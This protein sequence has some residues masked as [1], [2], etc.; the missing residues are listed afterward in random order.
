MNTISLRKLRIPAYTLLV[1]TLGACAGNKER[2]SGDEIDPLEPAN[3]NMFS[4]NESLDENIFKPV[5]QGYVNITSAPVRASVTNFF[6]NAS[7][8]NTILNSFLQGE[9]GHGFADIGRFVVNSTLG[10][11]GLFDVATDMGLPEREKDTGQTLARWGAGEGAY[12]FIPGP[13]SNTIRDSSNMVTS[14]LLFPF[15]Y[16]SAVVLLPVT[17]VMA[18]NARANLLTASNIRDEA[19][20]DSYSFTREVYLQQ[21][22]NLIYGK[23][24]P[25]SDSF[26]GF[27]DEYE[28]DIDR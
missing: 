6:D 11:G 13:G 17:A 25:F 2:I 15:T 27:E 23:P 9:F 1:I 18:I 22:Q 21:R 24:E 8:L 4:L 10:I 19:A 16:F 7:Y 20:L 5:A 28:D 14:S 26:E 12:L 3:R